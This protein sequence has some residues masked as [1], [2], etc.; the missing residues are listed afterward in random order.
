MLFR[1]LAALNLAYLLHEPR[2]SGVAPSG[3]TTPGAAPTLDADATQRIDELIGR[4]DR[5]LGQDGHL[6]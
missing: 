6:I 1:S 3:E 4:L 2:P 5:I